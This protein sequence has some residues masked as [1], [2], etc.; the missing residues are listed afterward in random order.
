M[1][2]LQDAK[3]MF[4]NR[5]TYFNIPKDGDSFRDVQTYEI[6]FSPG[7]SLT[8]T[9]PSRP[10]VMS[11][12]DW[13]WTVDGSTPLKKV[14]DTLFSITQNEKLTEELISEAVMSSLT[15]MGV[16][17]TDIKY[18][19]THTNTP[20]TIHIG[21]KINVPTLHH[22]K[23]GQ[24][25]EVHVPRLSELKNFIRGVQTNNLIS[26]YKT[27]LFVRPKNPRNDAE[28]IAAEAH[29]YHKNPSLY[30]TLWN[31]NSLQRNARIASIEHI[32][33]FVSFAVVM[34]VHSL[35]KSGVILVNQGQDETV[36]TDVGTAVRDAVLP[37]GNF[38]NIDKIAANLAVLLNVTSPCNTAAAQ[39]DEYV[40]T[41]NEALAFN[42][43]RKMFADFRDELLS[44]ILF[45]PDF[46]DQVQRQIGYNGDHPNLNPYYEQ[47]PDNPGE[48]ILPNNNPIA[49]LLTTQ[50]E[51]F[52]FALMSFQQLGEVRSS[53]SAGVAVGSSNP[54]TMAE[55]YW[56]K[57]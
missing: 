17:Y 54:N 53:R 14:H 37:T 22:I 40:A 28:V 35:L 52:S 48:I 43:N 7:N 15:F 25:L 47:A 19:D 42:Q 10:N 56:G 20:V 3:N 11:S 44:Q 38:L 8:H 36:L 18:K 6:L 26:K 55:I 24:Q 16:C 31:Q 13:V 51:A 21:G 2:S 9:Q 50:N 45:H 57:Q 4:I 49:K 46:K 1:Y 33:R 23:V 32:A 27:R 30:M 34:G 5:Q 12:L 29:L 41:M 39:L